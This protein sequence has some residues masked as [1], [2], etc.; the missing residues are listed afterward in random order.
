MS[1]KKTHLHIS[2]LAGISRLAVSATMGITDLAEELHKSITR[3]PGLAGNPVQGHVEAISK[4]VYE[5]VR[6]VTS[7][8]GSATDG[9]LAQFEPIL[10]EPGSPERE[11]VLAALN[12][13]VGDHLA[14]SGNSLAITM[15]LRRNG[16][17]LTVEKEALAVAF[18]AQS[19][20]VRP[21]A[22]DK[23]LV[24]VHGLCMN[25]L[26]W[27]Q[28]SGDF[29]AALA[30]DLGYTTIHL[31]YNSG[32]HISTN[33]RTFASLLENLLEQ[34]PEAL[35]KFG[36]LA[37][38][39]GGLVARSA[40]HYG[41]AAGHRWPRR[42]QQLIF[43]GTPH[44]GAPLERMGNLVDIC[45]DVSP[46]SAP[47]ARLVKVRSAGIT[48]MRYGNLL[49]EDWQGVDRFKHKW[50]LRHPLPLPEGVLSYAI[51]GNLGK[52]DGMLIG[53]G[54]VSVNSALGRHKNPELTL[55][56][57][58][59]RQWVGYDMN[60]WNL[61]GRAE[62]HKKIMSWMGKATARTRAQPGGS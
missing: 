47:F 38:S 2:D 25:D 44:H 16:R 24:L 8:V 33:G 26:Q 19:D 50:D 58:P 4:L 57:A 18:S 36:I 59:S 10:D 39:M 3:S 21:V 51:A 31:H 53:D 49:D 17:P 29:E 30:R 13:V 20:A 11:A 7:L 12:G 27:T 42:L 9:A 6:G 48:D 14:A 43:L 54:M 61:L 23:L 41:M 45:L 15:Q 62:V 32:L 1:N 52:K 5:S 35:N 56:F 37:H 22:C 46:Y 60:H 34:W 55:S 28:K 40:Y